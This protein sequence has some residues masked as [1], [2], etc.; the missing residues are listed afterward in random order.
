MRGL[1]VALALAACC[2][3]ALAALAADDPQPGA[4]SAGRV[5]SAKG[6]SWPPEAASL[7]F[8]ASARLDAAAALH[9]SSAPSMAGVR[10][11]GKLANV[12]EIASGVQPT[13]TI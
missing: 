2:S 10:C 7:G 9:D 4:G 1:I 6:Q 12:E 11:Q 5:R 8:E 3:T 13:L